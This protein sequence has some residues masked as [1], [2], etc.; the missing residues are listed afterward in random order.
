LRHIDTTR[1]GKLI[2]DEDSIITFPEGLIEHPYLRE[3]AILGVEDYFPF[4]ILTSVDES[5]DNI[6]FPIIKP[7]SVFPDYEPSLHEPERRLLQVGSLDDIQSYC[8]VSFGID[9]PNMNVNLKL[10]IV[11]NIS[12][13]T[14]CQVVLNGDHPYR[15]ESLDLGRII[16]QSCP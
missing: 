12:R 8:L 10:P 2:I 9:Q 1:F 16:G 14:G 6:C 13:M 4:L 11:I 15:K 3:F 5:K 7:A